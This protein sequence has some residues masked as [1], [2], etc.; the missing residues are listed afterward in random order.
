M[1]NKSFWAQCIFAIILLSIFS[2]CDSKSNQMKEMVECIKLA[3]TKANNIEEDASS[4]TNINDLFT[5]EAIFKKVRYLI[6]NGAK[7]DSIT[8]IGY[9]WFKVS[10]D[11]TNWYICESG[12]QDGLALLYWKIKKEDNKLK[13][14]NVAYAYSQCTSNIKDLPNVDRIKFWFKTIGY[15]EVQPYFQGSLCKVR[16]SNKYG[17]INIDGMEIIPCKYDDIAFIG[18]DL[19]KTDEI[20]IVL[21]D[22]RDSLLHVKL[23]DKFGF[24]NLEGTE[25]VP[26]KYDELTIFEWN[27]KLLQVK[28]DNKYGLINF[29]GTEIVPCKYDELTIF[30]WNEKLL[31]VKLDNKY[32]LINFE[33]T[34]IIPCKYD[35]FTQFKWGIYLREYEKLLQVKLDNKYGLI[36]LEKKEIIPCKY[37]SIGHYMPF[38]DELSGAIV[39]LDDKY[40]LIDL[41][42]KEIIPCLFEQI[43]QDGTLIKVRKENLCCYYECFGTQVTEFYEDINYYYDDLDHPIFAAKSNGKWGY[44][45]EDGDILISFYLDYAGTPYKDG[46]A[47]AVY[48]GYSGEIDLRS[49]RFYISNDNSNDNST[50]NSISRKVC[51]ECGGTGT[52]VIRGNGIV[53]GTQQCPACGGLGYISVPSYW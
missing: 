48:K 25:I 16:N 32:G 50:N 23:N 45:N 20:E 34:E 19:F 17:F 13:L 1:N 42:G 46:T 41:E 28:L 11:L 43:S 39:K 9:N 37:D 4:S 12:D 51:P 3:H 53:L 38:M 2:S 36:N 10:Y 40:G 21:D 8:Y 33:G 49:G 22:S 6:H 18:G 44:L 7:L 27:E 35:D 30:E 26:C 31:Q 5:S 14:D 15:D 29:E 52:M 47:Y 24:I